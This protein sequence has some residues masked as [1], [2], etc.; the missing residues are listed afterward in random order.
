MLHM[1][2][3]LYIDILPIVN[4]NEHNTT[5]WMKIRR[6]YF[7]DISHLLTTVKQSRTAVNLI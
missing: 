4:V 6:T 3:Q 5:S 2:L 7:T 1:L